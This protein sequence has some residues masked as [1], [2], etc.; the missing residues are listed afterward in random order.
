ML[1]LYAS[2]SRDLNDAAQGL[3]H[4]LVEIRSQ[5]RASWPRLSAHRTEVMLWVGGRS[6]RRWWR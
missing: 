6:R 4:F 1:K 5:M 3:S 2:I